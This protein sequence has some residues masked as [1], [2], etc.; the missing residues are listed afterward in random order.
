[1]RNEPLKV[2]YI[3]DSGDITEYHNDGQMEREK[4]GEK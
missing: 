1:M 4:E 2:K 3:R